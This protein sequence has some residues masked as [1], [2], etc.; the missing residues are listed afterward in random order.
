MQNLKHFCF[1]KN[2]VN[3]TI[4]SSNSMFGRANFTN[5][6]AKFSKTPVHKRHMKSLLYLPNKD[7]DMTWH[8]MTWQESYFD[9]FWR[10]Q[11]IGLLHKH[12]P[13]AHRTLFVQTYCTYCS[14]LHKNNITRKTTKKP[15]YIK[16]RHYLH[17]L[18]RYA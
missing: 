4:M 18:I 14:I 10:N 1:R 17:S 5:T 13:I 16:I 8:D 6:F 9:I 11:P 3:V 2:S 7:I 15:I 12:V